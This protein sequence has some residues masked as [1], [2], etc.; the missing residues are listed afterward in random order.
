MLDIWQHEPLLLAAGFTQAQC[1]K[2]LHLLDKQDQLHT[3]VDA[4]VR[5]WQT[6]PKLRVL[7]WLR[8][9][10]RSTFTS[11]RQLAKALR[12]EL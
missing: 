8:W 2:K 12:T 3:G 5:L 10:R 4:M 6:V 1:L 11:A 9:A 7:A